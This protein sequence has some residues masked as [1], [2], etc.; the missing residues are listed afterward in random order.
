MKV[1]I[2]IIT[3]NSHNLFLKQLERINRHCKDDFEVVIVDNSTGQESIDAIKYYCDK[4]G[5]RLIKT[6]ASSK[7]G[8]G[9]HSFSANTSY[10][11]LKDEADFFFYMDHDLMP[12]K[13]FSVTE[14]LDGKDFAAVGQ[15]KNG[16]LYP[17][18]GCLMFRKGMDIDFSPS[19]ELGLDTGG[20]IH[21]LI[22]K[23]NM[24]HL[25][26]ERCQNP[27]FNKSFY[28]FYVM[29]HSGTFMHFLAGS[30]WSNKEHHEERINSL[31]NILDKK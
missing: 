24:V 30:N 31:L 6:N 23:D 13:N 22:T 20:M 16:I 2:V 3:Y 12:V 7:N 18:P 9:S 17:W 29:I 5:L 19:H 15:I 4:I 10:Q 11:M 27:E 26:E 8:S 25:T 21:R 28:D 14:I 1:Y